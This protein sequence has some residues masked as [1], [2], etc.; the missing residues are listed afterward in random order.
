MLMKVLLAGSQIHKRNQ[1]EG[2][3]SCCSHRFEQME[4]VDT[5]SAVVEQHMVR[6]NYLWRWGINQKDIDHI[7]Q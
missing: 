7:N 1:V 3:K 4:R 5:G 6:T 2:S